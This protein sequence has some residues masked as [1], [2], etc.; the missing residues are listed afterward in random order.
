MRDLFS[1][2]VGWMMVASHNGYQSGDR[3]E[4]GEVR[5]DVIDVGVLRT[6]IAEIGDWDERGEHSTGRIVSFPNS[7][8]LDSSVANY[9]RG[10]ET[11]W[12]EISVMVTFESDWQAAE[13]I[14]ESLALED[15][16]ENKTKFLAMMKRGKRE[17]MVTYNYLTPKVYVRI[18]DSG[19]RLTLR[20]M[21]ETRKRRTIT[22]KFNRDILLAFGDNDKIDFA[23]PTTRFY[24][25]GEGDVQ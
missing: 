23:Y 21:V 15:Y 24:R 1:N 4:I 12:N 7:M 8:V 17:Y 3:V 14:L 22:D 2:F 25:A 10:F 6:T 11:I 19:V 20:H 16:D 5:G 9:N 18:L 13:E